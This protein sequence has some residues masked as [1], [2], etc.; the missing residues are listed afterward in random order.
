MILNIAISVILKSIF[1][2][3]HPKIDS[4]AYGVRYEKMIEKLKD[5]GLF[6]NWIFTEYK[7]TKTEYYRS[8]YNNILTVRVSTG[9]TIVPKYRVMQ[10]GILL[11]Y[12][13]AAYWLFYVHFPWWV[14]VIDVGGGLVSAYYCMVWERLYYKIGGQDKEIYEYQSK[15]E[16]VY[17]LKRIYFSGKWLFAGGFAGWKFDVSAAIGLIIMYL[18]SLIFLYN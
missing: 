17:W 4:E 13:T 6:W 9:N 3:L 12:W 2:Y 14:T 10:N 8:A 7:L 16:D 15:N 1:N 5:A 11:L 18:C